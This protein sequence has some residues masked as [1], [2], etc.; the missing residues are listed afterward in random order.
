[1]CTRMR[2]NPCIFGSILRCPEFAI[3]SLGF[4]QA[5]RLIT[6]IAIEGPAV[7]SNWVGIDDTTF[8]ALSES[9]L[10]VAIQCMHRIVIVSLQA[11]LIILKRWKF[12]FVLRF[13][14]RLANLGWL[15][16]LWFMMALTW[17]WAF[18][19]VCRHWVW[20]RWAQPTWD[21]SWAWF[22]TLLLPKERP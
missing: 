8:M 20:M 1:M 16:S 6:W 18:E 9:T 15:H 12:T 4:D 11:G 10:I 14:M 22:A 13:R 3:A 5:A 7:R 21:H 17:R 19:L 2:I